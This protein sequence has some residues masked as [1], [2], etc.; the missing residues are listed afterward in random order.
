M[1]LVAPQCT[2]KH[3][4]CTVLAEMFVTHNDLQ[5]GFIGICHRCWVPL[6][7]AETLQ[8]QTGNLGA[9]QATLHPVWLALYIDM[10]QIY[11]DQKA[12]HSL[13]IASCTKQHTY[14]PSLDR[15][16]EVISCYSVCAG[17]ARCY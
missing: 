17:L 14:D 2:L 8:E 3:E 5:R 10:H 4:G 13:L 12:V 9:E 16:T 6:L 11:H 1:S 7:D 15:G